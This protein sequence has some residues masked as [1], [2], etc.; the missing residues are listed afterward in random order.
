MC[1]RVCFQYANP[2]V[3]MAVSEFPRVS[4]CVCLS[5][6]LWWGGV[7]LRPQM[8]V[9]IGISTFLFSLAICKRGRPSV[10]SR[11]CLYAQKP[12]LS[13]LWVPEEGAGKA[14]CIS[15]CVCVHVWTASGVR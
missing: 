14:V 3:E 13:G 10:V 8:C 4:V 11:V 9:C 2:S 15:G 7:P 1:T 12:Q 5:A 6:C